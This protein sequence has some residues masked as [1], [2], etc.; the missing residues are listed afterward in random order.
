MLELGKFQTL[1]VLRNTPPGLFLGSSSGEEVLLPNKYI[2][3]N[4]NIGD[5]IEVFVYLDHEERFVAT[6]I[7]PYI[8]I[9]SFG[10]LE[11]VDVTKSG[12]FLYWGL[13]KDLFVP[14][15]E[16]L[17]QM[18]VGQ[19]CLVYMYLDK[20][21]NR[22]VASERIGKFLK[23]EQLT[24]QENQEVDLIIGNKTE[25][26][27]N[28]VINE[29]HLG[30]VYA[31]DIYLPIETGDKIKGFIKKIREDN[32]ID[33]TLQP[34]GYRNIIEPSSQFIIDKLKKKG[35]FISL[36]DNSSPELIK[37]EMNMSKKNF[38]KTIG[39]LYKQKLIIIKED[40]IYLV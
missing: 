27:F 17:K 9:N 32:K 23:N 37:Q 4:T 33:V 26:G 3:K 15:N 24:I 19:F 29:L 34:M 18:K 20:S 36:N 8:Q 40:G 7:Q 6:T 10:L 13:E 39:L 28:V 30:L 1:E 5:K 31:D 22:L 16:Q 35:G 12:A 25:L 38:K 14:F 21:T 2:P 11:V